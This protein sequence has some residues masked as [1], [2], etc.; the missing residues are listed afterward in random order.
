MC[1]DPPDPRSRQGRRLDETKHLVVVGDLGERER[2]QQRQHLRPVA[3]VAAGNLTDHERVG[4]HLSFVEIA[5]KGRVPVAEVL[6]PNRGVDEHS[7]RR[8]PPLP[9]PPPGRAT[10]AV[11]APPQGCEPPRA[12]TRDERLQSRVD[13][14]GFLGDPGEALSFVEQIVVEVEC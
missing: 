11:L 10:Q 9:N 3:Q 14:G 13:Y 7:Q 6:H 4:P 2:L 8:L 1:V 12:L 5:G